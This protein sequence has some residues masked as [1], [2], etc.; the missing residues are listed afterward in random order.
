MIVVIQKVSSASVE[1]TGFPTA[2]ISNGYCILLGIREDDSE[3]DIDYLVQKILKAQLFEDQKGRFASTIIENKGEILII[4]Q[5]TLYGDV[6]HKSSPSFT[7]AMKPES[8]EKL[9]HKFCATMEASGL[10]IATGVF[11]AYMKL[12]IVNEGPVT[13]ILSSDHKKNNAA[14]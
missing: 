12:N 11:R 10:K 14:N 9:F 3:T 2:A 7:H 1:V 4:P 8:A 6:I 13:F 5:F